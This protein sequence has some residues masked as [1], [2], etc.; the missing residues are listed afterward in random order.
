MDRSKVLKIFY[1][2]MPIKVSY[3]EFINWFYDMGY[4]IIEKLDP[5]QSKFMEEWEAT[6][7]HGT[8]NQVLVQATEA[9][10]RLIDKHKADK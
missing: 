5:P 7:F 1:E 4:E 9:L 6:I 2:D 8:S 10:A 3:V